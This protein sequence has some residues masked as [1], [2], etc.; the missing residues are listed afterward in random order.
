MVGR[1]FLLCSLGYFEE[2]A[3]PEA[4]DTADTS[5]EFVEHE[6]EFIL[7]HVSLVLIAVQLEYKC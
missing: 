2:H 5:A 4:E 3:F 1:Q 7:L 6:V